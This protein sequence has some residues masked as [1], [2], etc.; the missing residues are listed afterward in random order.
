[1][2][3]RRSVTFLRTPSSMAFPVGRLLVS[4]DGVGYV[5]A[6]DG[7]I[8]LGAILPAVTAELSRAGAEDWCEQEGWDLNLLDEAYRL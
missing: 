7:W 8:R 2:T 1:M 5:L 4:V 6:A 3:D